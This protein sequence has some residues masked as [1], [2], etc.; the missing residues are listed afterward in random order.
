MFQRAT[1]SEVPAGKKITYKLAKLLEVIP[2]ISV[3]IKLNPT[4]KLTTL[5]VKLDEQKAQMSTN[6]L[7]KQLMVG[8]PSV[9]VDTLDIFDGF[10]TINPMCLRNGDVKSIASR[11][12]DLLGS[13]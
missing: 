12:Q 7:V 8:N 4:K 6:C 1:R 3:S 11:V 9:H 10:F 5:R 2:N 13:G